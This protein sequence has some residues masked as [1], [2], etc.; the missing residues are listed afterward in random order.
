MSYC[1]QDLMRMHVVEF[2]SFSFL[3]IFFFR[4]MS[5]VQ[6]KKFLRL[7]IETYHRFRIQSP[8]DSTT[9]LDSIP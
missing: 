4:T 8:W 1:I 5:G 6:Y 9:D 2:V 3:L 7:P